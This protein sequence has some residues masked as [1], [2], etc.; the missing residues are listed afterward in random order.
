MVLVAHD[1]LLVCNI[2]ILQHGVEKYKQFCQCNAKSYKNVQKGNK[3]GDLNASEDHRNTTLT[4]IKVNTR[5]HTDS[6]RKQSLT[7][8]SESRLLWQ[9]RNKPKNMSVDTIVNMICSCVIDVRIMCSWE[10]SVYVLLHEY[11]NLRCPIL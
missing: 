3:Q 8:T 9:I 7:R 4:C 5:P 11:S 10:E 6:P 2:H 1:L